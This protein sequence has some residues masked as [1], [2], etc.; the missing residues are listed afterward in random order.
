MKTKNIFLSILVFFVFCSVSSCNK[1]SNERL[2]LLKVNQPASVLN[3][4]TDSLLIKEK[5]ISFL[6]NQFSS[7][8]SSTLETVSLQT[9]SRE[10]QLPSSFNFARKENV[11]VYIVN[12]KN[13]E[14]EPAG[15]V[16]RIGLDKISNPVLAFSDQGSWAIT[17]TPFVDMFFEQ[18]D[19][20]IKQE[21]ENSISLY[22][23]NSDDCETELLNSDTNETKRECNMNLRW[24]QGFPYNVNLPTC[25]D[26]GSGGHTPAGCVAIAL[27]Q[28]MA[29]HEKPLSGYYIS[30]VTGQGIT[31]SYN[32]STMK[33]RPTIYDLSV[34]G[35]AQIANLIAEIGY[36]TN[37]DYGCSGSGAT[38]NDAKSCLT[39][40]GYSNTSISSYN[41][42]NVIAELAQG[43]PVYMRGTNSQNEGHAWVV[44]G[45]RIIQS[46]DS[47]VRRCPNSA[48]EYYDDQ[49]SAYYLY[50]NLGLEP[51]LNAYYAAWSGSIGES[52]QFNYDLKTITNIR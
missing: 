46:I 3:I 14:G 44:E 9:V 8:R 33:A 51:G 52:F 42:S 34:V 22:G 25:I 16:I 26:G 1:E 11:P 21:I 29:F 13:A 50:F 38:I 4:E 47:Y 30:K 18:A 40:M 39:S 31:T 43:Y 12:L 23:V 36:R 6:R 49:Q 27:G 37:M 32:W 48:D 7:L 41:R 10:I 5:S 17:D 19:F 45:Y 28:I 20:I 2:D 35:Q 24:I 15:F